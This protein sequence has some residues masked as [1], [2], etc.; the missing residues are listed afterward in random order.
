MRAVFDTNILIDYLNGN[1]QAKKEIEIYEFR[2]I[3][4]IT[5]IEIIVGV[6]NLK[7]IEF[8]KNF[9]HRFSIIEIDI[10]IAELTITARKKY[11]LKIPDALILATAEQNQ[12]LLVTRDTKDF[13]ETLPIVRVPYTINAHPIQ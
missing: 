13:S 11:K 10:P 8:I 5:Y 1:I 4:I 12:C 6:Q 3:S 9:L 2:A 7:E